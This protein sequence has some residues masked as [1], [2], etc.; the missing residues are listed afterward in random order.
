MRGKSCSM[1]GLGEQPSSYT[2]DGFYV[3]GERHENLPAGGFAMIPGK[4]RKGMPFRGSQRLPGEGF[5]TPV[6]SIWQDTRP[7]E[8]ATG[9]SGMF[10]GPNPK[11]SKMASTAQMADFGYGKLA[12]VRGAKVPRGYGQD[13]GSDSTSTSLSDILSQGLSTVSDVA[14]ALGPADA[15]ASTPAA[16]AAAAAAK[17]ATASFMST[18]IAGVPVVAVLAL[19]GVAAFF[20]MKKK[21]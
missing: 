21:R 11:G 13:D 5:G 15:Q 17:P 3:P 9:S 2:G 4:H 14:Q 8:Y 19:A 12:V 16:K 20:V 6:Y 18:K 7:P 10:Q 1:D